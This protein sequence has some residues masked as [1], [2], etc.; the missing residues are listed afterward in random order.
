MF[1]S[2]NRCATEAHCFFAKG[3]R[4][5]C[6][7]RC[8]WTRRDIE[9]ADADDA[10][11]AG[12]QDRIEPR[13]VERLLGR[14]EESSPIYPLVQHVA[15]LA[16]RAAL[17]QLD[18]IGFCSFEWHRSTVEKDDYRNG[19]CQS[20]ERPPE[21]HEQVSVCPRSYDPPRVPRK[22]LGLL[23]EARDEI[24][25]WLAD[26]TKDQNT[27]RELGRVLGVAMEPRDLVHDAEGHA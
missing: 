2:D 5:D 8:N 27:I 4:T 7:A 20:C 16:V 12:W 21:E 19:K 3:K 11:F 10:L 6:C 23:D 9:Q 22:A 18:E 17:E 1:K 24:G 25:S 13:V 15:A 26:R 14:N